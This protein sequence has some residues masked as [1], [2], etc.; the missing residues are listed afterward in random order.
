MELNFHK[1]I[2]QAMRIDYPLKTFRAIESEPLC[3]KNFPM[4][5]AFV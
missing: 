4:E 5:L 3:G 1:V 2:G